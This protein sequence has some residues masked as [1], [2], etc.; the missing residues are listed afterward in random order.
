MKALFLVMLMSFT[1]SSFAISTTDLIKACEKVGA[2]K[3]LVKAQ[4]L[5]VEI[6]SDTIQE[7]GVDNR[8]LNPSKYV[9]FCAK[10]KDETKVIRT[11]TQYS[12]GNCF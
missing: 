8:R 3:I 1:T 4:T 5:G 2:E 7:C 11:L 9:W 6:E 12:F 10:V